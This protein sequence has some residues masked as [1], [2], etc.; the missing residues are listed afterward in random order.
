VASPVV[1]TE[2]REERKA[3]LNEAFR[4]Y[5]RTEKIREEYRD[6][7]TASGGSPLI[8]QDVFPVIGEVAKYFSPLLD[9]VTVEQNTTARPTKFVTENDSTNFLTISSEGTAPTEVDQTFSDTILSHDLITGTVTASLQLLANSTEFDFTKLIT[10]AA[11]KRL[12]RSY[13]S[14]ITNGRDPASNAAPGN[15]GL[16]NAATVGTTTSVLANGISMAD[17][18]NLVSSVDPTWWSKA[19]F[20]I[21]G[22][23]YQYLMKQVDGSGR[24]FWKELGEGRLWQ[25]PVVINN[26]LP[27]SFTANGLP[28]LFGDFS[29]YGVSHTGLSVQVLRERFIEQLKFGFV[30]SSRIASQQLSPDGYKA[31]KLAAS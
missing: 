4:E 15:Q 16:V 21:S 9:Y 19:A 8:P 22:G 31:L 10:R 6:I 30:L 23:T 26:A 25:W 2:P 27:Q 17:L 13:E 24:R 7:F 14:L 3:K 28:V 18:A 12:G 11:G 20:M 5:L 29:T 1:R